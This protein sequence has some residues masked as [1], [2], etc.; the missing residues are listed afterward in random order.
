MAFLKA[1]FIYLLSELKRNI[2]ERVFTK[3]LY[4][5]FLLNPK[6]INIMRH[7]NHFI[8][9]ALVL[10]MGIFVFASCQQQP[11]Y[12]AEITEE[13]GEEVAVLHDRDNNTHVSIAVSV[14]NTMYEL[15]VNDTNHLSFPVSLKAYSN[16]PGKF[17]NPFLYPWGN[18]LEGD[19]YYFND[20][21]ITLD[22]TIESITLERDGN[23]LPIHGYLT[24]NDAWE[25]VDYSASEDGGATHTA[26][27]DFT[28]HPDLMKNY[29]FPHVVRM[30]HALEDGVV[31]IELTVENTGEESMPLA[32]GFH[33]YYKI[34]PMETNDS[35]LTIPAENYMELDSLLL[36]TGNLEDINSLISDPR[37]YR[38]GTKLID[39]IFTEF[40]SGNDYTEFVLQKPNHTV[41]IQIG[42]EYKYT[43]V[44]S[45]LDK[46]YPYVCVEPMMAPTNG[47]NLYHKGD[48]DHLPIVQA[49]EEHT[50]TF[51]ISIE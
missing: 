7:F 32:Y 24:K 46:D 42:P 28:E 49:G 8:R 23:G 39:H 16:S 35:Y 14:G 11:Q 27:I 34:P 15:M 17:G 20:Q 4:L 43:T 33:T 48:W 5:H 19:Y 40:N 30:K 13:D 10:T 22:T 37:Q 45:P 50:S 31:S 3:Y 2:P 29:P 25:T 9:T 6:Q 1:F 36:P 47:F 51:R 26:E 38:I 12:S 21:K 41:N 18:R 44:Y